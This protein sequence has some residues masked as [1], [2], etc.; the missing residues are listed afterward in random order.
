MMEDPDTGLSKQKRVSFHGT[1]K[2]KHA[3]M[4]VLGAHR[5]NK[6]GGKIGA[7]RTKRV[8][9]QCGRHIVPDN[10]RPGGCR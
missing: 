10:W 4:N 5:S 2:Q 8:A 3:V 9:E 7:K 1:S 6:N